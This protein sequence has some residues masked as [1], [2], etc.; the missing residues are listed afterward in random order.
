MKKSTDKS[1]HRKLVLRLETISQLT[2]LQLRNVA[3]GWTDYWPCQ[4][5]SEAENACGDK[6]I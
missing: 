5:A 4:S 2:P 3:G 6:P 1:R